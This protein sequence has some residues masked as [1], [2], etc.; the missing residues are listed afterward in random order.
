[1]AIA[2]YRLI[3]ILALILKALCLASAPG[4]TTRAA[5][6]LLPVT[7]A[8]LGSLLSMLS[9]ESADL[10]GLMARAYHR[11]I[12]R[13]ALALCWC[14]RFYPRWSSSMTC[15]ST[16]RALLPRWLSHADACLSP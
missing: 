15:S 12:A 6:A 3:A 9:L 16:P 13:H 2:L 7:S 4:L 11:L 14:Q 5:I 8:L 10:A 1:M